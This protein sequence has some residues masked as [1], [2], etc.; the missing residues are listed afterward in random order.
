MSDVDP[1]ASLAQLEQISA[2]TLERF[3]PLTQEQLDGRLPQG[4]AS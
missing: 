2:E 4:E 3:E 1:A